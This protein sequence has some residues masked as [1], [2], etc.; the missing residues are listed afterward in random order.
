MKLISGQRLP[1]VNRG[2]HSVAYPVVNK[3]LAGAIRDRRRGFG[4]QLGI[5]NNFTTCHSFPGPGVVIRIIGEV[6]PERVA[7][8]RKADYVFMSMIYN[9]TRNY[10]V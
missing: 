3:A 1:I 9:D 10:Y 6:T 2:H 5:H 7:T 8:A 4:K